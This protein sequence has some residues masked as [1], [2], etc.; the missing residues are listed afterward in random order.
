M[1]LPVR[2]LV[3]LALALGRV[4]GAMVALATFARLLHFAGVQ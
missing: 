1:S 3:G 2:S 4:V